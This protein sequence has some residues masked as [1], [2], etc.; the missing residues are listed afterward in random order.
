[1]YFGDHQRA[2]WS[3]FMFMN[4]VSLRMLDYLCENDKT[5]AEKMLQIFWK[6]GIEHA[7]RFARFHDECQRNYLAALI[8]YYYA[9]FVRDGKDIKDLM[10]FFHEIKEMPVLVVTAIS[11][12]I[13][14]GASWEELLECDKD[15]FI[16]AIRRAETI[17]EG[18]RQYRWIGSFLKKL[19]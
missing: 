14:N 4:D 17:A 18:Q 8:C 6:D 3:H 13:K 7:R 12:L 10:G 19:S 9:C 5:Q 11:M 1:M 2:L 16:N 15:Y